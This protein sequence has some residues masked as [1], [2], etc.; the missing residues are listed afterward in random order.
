MQCMWFGTEMAAAYQRQNQIGAAL[1]KCHQIEKNFIEITDDQFDFHTYCMRKVTL[2]AYIRL[3]NLEDLLRSHSFYFK[4]AKIAIEC[5]LYLYDKP[6]MGDSA[7]VDANK[8]NLSSKELKK[9][10]SKERRAKKKQAIEDEKKVAENK[11]NK[12]NENKKEDKKEKIDP[13]QLAKTETPLDEAKNFL[14]WLQKLCKHRIETHLMAFEIYSRKGRPLLMLQSLLRGKACEPENAQLHY[15]LI[16]FLATVKKER[17][18]YSDIV[19]SVLDTQIPSLLGNE[20]TVSNSLS[21]ANM[22]AL[23]DDFLLRHGDSLQARSAV[24]K[25]KLLLGSG[26]QQEAVDLIT[27]LSPELSDRCLQTCEANLKFLLSTAN[28]S[29]EALEYKRSCAEVFPYAVVF[30]DSSKINESD[31]NIADT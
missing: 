27:D 11:E 5:Y 12:E 7:D 26:T 6:L 4:A 13:D 9:L 29:S 23:N 16:Q 15:C 21:E 10:K 2:C 20:E 25:S 24:G 8:G 22:N 1:R 31:D 17:A 14:E 18:N 28:L 19:N 3:L 30:Q